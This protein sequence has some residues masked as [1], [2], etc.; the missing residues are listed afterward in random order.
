M[1]NHR[2]ILV[3][4]AAACLISGLLLSACG[5]LDCVW[6]PEHLRDRPLQAFSVFLTQGEITKAR[7]DIFLEDG[8]VQEIRWQSDFQGPVLEPGRN[9]SW[10]ESL[11]TPL[12]S[13]NILPL[14]QAVIQWMADNR[15]GYPD[16]SLHYFAAY[17][18]E[19]AGECAERL[20]RA[21]ELG[22]PA[23]T[24]SLAREKLALWEPDTLPEGLQGYM[25][26]DGWDGQEQLFYPIFLLP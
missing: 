13:Q 21:R 1:R 19:L 22:K 16:Y 7:S 5:A 8:R 6:M 12:T 10:R 15:P 11:N 20:E 4:W 14:A 17:P 26:L 3:L 23:L 24:Y 2:K 18:S 25:I 9:F